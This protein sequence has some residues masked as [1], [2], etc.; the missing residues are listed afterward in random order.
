MRTHNQVNFIV[1]EH[2]KKRCMRRKIQPEWIKHALEYPVRIESDSDDGS[3]VHAIWPVP[4]KG[5]RV[6][7]VIYNETVNPVAV[8]TAYFDNEV[9]AP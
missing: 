1:T 9:I 7:R 3:L 8:V 4:E 6:L 5:Y 2:A